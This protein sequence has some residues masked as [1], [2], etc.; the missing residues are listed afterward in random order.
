M[1]NKLRKL[2]TKK[3]CLSGIYN[4]PAIATGL[5]PAAIAILPCILPNETIT[6]HHALSCCSMI[7]IPGGFPASLIYCMLFRMMIKQYLRKNH[8]SESGDSVEDQQIIEEERGFKIM[9]IVVITP[10]KQQVSAFYI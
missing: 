4:I 5:L 6:T 1:K 7:P 10:Y 3:T 8:P 9:F 2:F